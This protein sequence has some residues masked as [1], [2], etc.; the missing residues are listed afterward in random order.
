MTD[1][2]PKVSIIMLNWNSY[3]MTRDCLLS[4]RKI[5]YP[6]FEVILVDN[7]SVDSSAEQLSRE[8]PEIELIRNPRNLG[9]AGGNNVGM[10]KA[11]GRGTDYLLLL[12]NDTIVAS[13]FLRELVR[14]GE[15]D[16]SIGML[17]PKIYFFEPADRLWYGG[18][19]CRPWRVFPIHLGLRKHDDGSYDQTRE[20]SF[21]TGCALLI[22]AGVVR[23]IGL[24]DEA[25]F[26]SFE[27]ADWS[28]RA[29]RAG[30]KQF[31]VPGSV[32]WH[33]DSYDTTRNLG[34]AGK[35]FHTM[36]NSV[37]FARKYIEA[38]YWPLFMLSVGKYVIYR[39]LADLA[40]GEVKRVTA[41]YRG[42]W[43]GCRTRISPAPSPIPERQ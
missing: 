31:Y 6:T 7:G 12:N 23:R 30:F 27:D 37:L 18:G 39:T 40:R 25:F 28:M 26:L 38:P 3:Q 21:A 35:N 8:F 16:P 32:I 19:I 20:V 4:L 9:F 42:L 43:S 24:L 1:E 33:K 5:E 17:N 15:S 41:L 36:R 34:H 14:V 2:A 22:K 13:N 11:L 10:R 29:S